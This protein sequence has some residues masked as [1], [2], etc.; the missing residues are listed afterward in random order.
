MSEAK[1]L[2]RLVVWLAKSESYRNRVGG[3]VYV[4]LRLLDAAVEAARK[5]RS[6]SPSVER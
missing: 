1:R 5:I 4:D 3:V 2:A 6:K